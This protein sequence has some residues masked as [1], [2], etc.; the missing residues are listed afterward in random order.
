MIEDEGHHS[1]WGRQ[2][3][4]V[5]EGVVLLIIGGAIPLPNEEDDVRSPDNEENLDTDRQPGSTHAKPA[6]AWHGNRSVPFIFLSEAEM[7][8]IR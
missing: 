2:E 8:S 7:H 1:A 5:V 3:L 4:P 6:T